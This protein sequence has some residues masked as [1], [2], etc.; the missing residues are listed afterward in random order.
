MNISNITARIDVPTC[1]SG[2]DCCHAGI[3]CPG[4][5]TR[6]HLHCVNDAGE[7]IG[8]CIGELRRELERRAT[9]GQ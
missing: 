8:A 4:C 3:H 7:K 9:T 2:E 1:A 6:N 5:Q